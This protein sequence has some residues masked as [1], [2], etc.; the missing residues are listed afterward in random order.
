V[1][2]S[3]SVNSIGVAILD[4]HKIIPYNAL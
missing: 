1:L 2:R 4:M 3:S